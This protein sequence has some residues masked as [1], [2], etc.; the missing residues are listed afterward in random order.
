MKKIMKRVVPLILVLA[1]VVCMSIPAMAASNAWITKM[2]TFPGRWWGGTND[3]YVGMIQAAMYAYGGSARTWIK[4]NG[5]TDCAYGQGTY[6]AVRDFQSGT[7]I[8]VD[9]SVG[10]ETWGTIARL[11]NKGTTTTGDWTPFSLSSTPLMNVYGALGDTFHSYTEWYY[12]R[13][14]HKPAESPYEF[15]R[16]A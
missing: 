14:D 8:G 10:S 5:G 6:Y 9:G 11:A 2:K 13:Y 16:Y 4:E 12:Y 3:G 1:M 7:K 15:F